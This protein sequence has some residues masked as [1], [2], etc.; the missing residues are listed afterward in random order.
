MPA[1]PKIIALSN[2]IL[3]KNAYFWKPSLA[4]FITKTGNGFPSWEASTAIDNPKLVM[5]LFEGLRTRVV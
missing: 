3:A 5:I 4:S 1:T 2:T